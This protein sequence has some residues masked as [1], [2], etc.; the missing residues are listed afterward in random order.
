MSEQDRMSELAGILNEV[1]HTG[2]DAEENLSLQQ[3][4][5]L[6]QF[7]RIFGMKH[8]LNQLEID[9]SGVY[10]Y[11]EYVG[12]DGLDSSQLKKLASVKGFEN[13]AWRDHKA[14]VQF[15]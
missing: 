7:E 15:K 4:K 1:K 5:A 2:K 8:V 12:T 3:A 6:T 9:E 11:F 10:A 13:L 14:E